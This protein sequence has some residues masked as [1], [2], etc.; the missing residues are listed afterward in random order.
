MS[1]VLKL[2][3]E[4]AELN[5]QLQALAA[6]E[7]GGQSLSAD[8]LTQFAALEKQIAEKT[9]QLA[10]AESAERAAAAAAV[11]LNESAAGINGPPSA[12]ASP[13]I[14]VTS[15]QAPGASVAQM[16]RLLAAAQGNQMQAAEMAKSGGFGSDVVMALSTVSPGA[17]GVLIPTNMASEV[18]ESLRPTSILRS[19][20]ARPIPLINGNMGLPRI[21]G[22]TSVGY[23]GMDTD[24][25]V[26]GMEFA[27]LKLQA[28]KLAA[29][30]PISNDLLKF[31][32]VNPGVD[33]IVVDDLFVSVGLYEDITFIRSNGNGGLTPK[34]LRYWT[35][36][37]NVVKAPAG[38]T[39]ADIDA[40]CGGLM[41]RVELANVNLTKCGWIMNPRTIRFLQTVRDGNGNLAYPE[42]QSGTF[43]GYP[44]KLSTQVPINLGAG[45]DESEIYFGDYSD[46]F[47]GETG[48]LLLAYSTEASYKDG[49]GDTVSAFQRDQTL[50]R[51]INHNDFGPRHV[52]SFAVGVEV[53]WGKDMLT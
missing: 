29:L 16:A 4:R 30:V 21:K 40:F 34:G 15:N 46:C 13:H 1:Q 52:E 26:T 20:G 5:T 37:A 24:I 9:E 25:P 51:V 10:R 28:K 47:I 17:G 7:A 27:D 33:Q 44:F 31:Q 38:A 42:I 19:F 50:V 6:K 53:K 39:M 23:I 45:S 36:P 14:T 35:P 49:N 8:E 32:G 11:P 22:N 48:Q 2:R 18:I 3:S 12:N 43:K 41:L